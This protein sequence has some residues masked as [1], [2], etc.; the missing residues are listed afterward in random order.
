MLYMSYD[1]DHQT[2]RYHAWAIATT[3]SQ[4][5]RDVELHQRNLGPSMK[6]ITQRFIELHIFK[7]HTSTAISFID[8]YF[9]IYTNDFIFHVKKIYVVI[10]IRWGSRHDRRRGE[11]VSEIPAC[12]NIASRRTNTKT[13]ASHIPSSVDIFLSYSNTHT[14]PDE[15]HQT[16]WRCNRNYSFNYD[17]QDC[18]FE[19]CLTDIDYYAEINFTHRHR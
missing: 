15:D 2:W 7:A 4:I 10:K 12:Q 14:V 5:K 19:P 1:E 17:L 16:W 3:C 18:V 11:I 8:R 13:H 6:I 9:H